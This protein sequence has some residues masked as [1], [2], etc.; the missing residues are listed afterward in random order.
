MW[1][2]WVRNTLYYDNHMRLIA[3]PLVHA[4]LTNELKQSIPRPLDRPDLQL[5]PIFTFNFNKLTF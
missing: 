4:F 1:V 2:Q 3:L 5:E